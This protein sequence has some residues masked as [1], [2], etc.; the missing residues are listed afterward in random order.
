MQK[1][2]LYLWFCWKH[3]IYDKWA[4]F[5]FRFWM[6]QICIDTQR[7]KFTLCSSWI[8]LFVPNSFL[9]SLNILYFCLFWQTCI[10]FFLYVKYC[11]GDGDTEVRKGYPFL[12]GVWSERKSHV[13]TTGSEPGIESLSVKTGK[14]LIAFFRY[15]K[16]LL[17]QNLA[18]FFKYC[19]NKHHVIIFP[20][21]QIYSEA[22]NLHTML[23][24][25]FL[26]CLFSQGWQVLT[27]KVVLEEGWFSIYFPQP[28]YSSLSSATGDNYIMWFLVLILVK[29]LCS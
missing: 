15:F 16:D 19:T 9:V 13:L 6:F 27:E 20:C 26:L 14:T 17:S 22:N 4:A 8:L 7:F 24:H 3:I 11:L 28:L 2:L 25:M 5:L 29:Y 21:L 18:L 23:K 12:Q 1:F 10:F